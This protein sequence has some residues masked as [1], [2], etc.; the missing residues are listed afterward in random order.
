MMND[1]ETLLPQANTSLS[2]DILTTSVDD[3]GKVDPW[4]AGRDLIFKIAFPIFIAFGTFSNLLVFVVMRSGSLRD[5]STCFYMSI[6]ALAD[7]GKEDVIIYFISNKSTSSEIPPQLC[8][9]VAFLAR[10]C[11]RH[12]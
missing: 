9:H 1:T 3:I 4:I 2:A 10:F 12:F 6:L 5:I 7:L 11:E 8:L